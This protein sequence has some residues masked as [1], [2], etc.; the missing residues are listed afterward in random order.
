MLSASRLAFLLRSRWTY[1]LVAAA[2]VL[3]RLAALLFER[4]QILAA[5]TEKSDDFARIFLFDGTFGLIPGQPS[6]YTQPLYSF[7]LIPIYWVFGR[8]WEAVGI[9]QILVALLA[10]L[11][12]VRVGRRW[13][14]P[15]AGLLAG[16]VATLHPYLVWHDVHLNREILDTALAAG[17][18]L[19]A[20]RVAERRTVRG[21]VGLGALLGLAVLSNTRLILLPVAVGL[22]LVALRGDRRRAVVLA[23]VT[24]LGAAAVVVPWVV[25][26]R[27]EVGCFAVT[28]DARA[29]WKANNVNTYETLSSNR[30]WIDNVPPYPNAPPTPE[31]AGDDYRVNGRTTVVDECAQMTFFQDRVFE[32]WQQ[33][34]GEKV[35]L[36]V[37]A[38]GMFLDPRAFETNNAD[39]TGT[40]LVSIMRRWVVPAYMIPLYALSLIGLVVVRR[41]VALLAVI[42]LA[43]NTGAVMVFAGATRYRV[44]FDFLFALLAAAAIQALVARRRERRNGG[45][46]PANTVGGATTA[47]AAPAEAGPPTP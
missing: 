29:L 10:A 5:Y 24:L 9:A 36:A 13:L 4:G 35:K 43:Y 28:T 20:L 25:R 47:G 2:C 15:A 45:P 14:S 18:V 16:L 33:H 34:P 21:A 31:Q 1:G 30:N 46:G 3:P 22:F 11:L 39:V 23:L 40:S 37:Q 8:H 6:A 17:L 41:R 44:P 38:T 32:F 19:L 12:V 27:I 7:F 26:N 42:L